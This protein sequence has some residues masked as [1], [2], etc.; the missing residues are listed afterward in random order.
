MTT[1]PTAAG[2]ETPESV[3]DTVLDLDEL[4]ASDVR[5]AE[6]TEILYTKPHLEAEIDALEAELQQLTDGS[7]SPMV[8][9]E[10]SLAEGP[11]GGRSA[12]VVAREIQEKRKEYAASGRSVRLKQLPSE[13]WTAF[14]TTWKAALSKGAP[15]PVA[16]WDD[17][18]SKCA[19]APEMPL[20]KVQALRAKLGHPPLHKL[21]MTCWDL[22]TTSGVSVPKSPLSSD[23]LRPRKRGMS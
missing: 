7:S 5:R 12:E 11:V 23:V 22:N 13:D 2:V 18:I 14:E 17:L 4:L 3:I 16:M 20:A 6:K 10:A 8:D 21:A 15:Y 1:E 19:V 9:E